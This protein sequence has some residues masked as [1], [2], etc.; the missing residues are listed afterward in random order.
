MQKLLLC[1][2]GIFILVLLQSCAPP[3]SSE[4]A[5]LSALQEGN[6]N[7][8]R[9]YTF[10]KEEKLRYAKN[11]LAD[12][13]THFKA[14]IWE[15]RMQQVDSLGKSVLA[16]IDS[17]QAGFEKE[18]RKDPN[19]TRDYFI[20]KGKG[21]ELFDRITAFQKSMLAVDHIVREIPVQILP[22]SL[23][24]ESFVQKYFA[25]SGHKAASVYVQHLGNQTSEL[26]FKTIVLFSE[27]WTYNRHHYD[28]YN[29]LVYQSS[30]VV[31]AGDPIE[32]IAGIGSMSR[33]A[34][35]KITINGEAIELGADAAAHKKLRA[36]TKPG[37]YS[38]PVKA[39]YVNTDGIRQWMSKEV[40]Y[41]VLP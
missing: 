37:T 30:N 41:T 38:I 8:R 2:A 11:A 22:D 27:Q 1:T 28:Y 9:H 20:E 13:V 36:V 29:L 26:T 10:S 32:I 40:R 24:A 16:F 6:N 19:A 31:R 23:D 14:S 25:S 34:Q 35:P 3:T 21:K 4:E 15:P 17:V 39:E 5:I 33:A 18:G 12:P 7:V